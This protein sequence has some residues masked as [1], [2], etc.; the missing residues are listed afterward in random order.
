M[1]KF[2]TS[3]GRPWTVGEDKDLI[4][5]VERYDTHRWEVVARFVGRRTCRKCQTRWVNWPDPQITRD[6]YS[7]MEDAK[8]R[9]LSIILP[10]HRTA[11]SCQLRHSF[12]HE[13]S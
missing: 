7:Q 1:N 8:F 6:E 3:S 11:L 4:E 12:L 5:A 10:A 2:R 13:N 9:Q